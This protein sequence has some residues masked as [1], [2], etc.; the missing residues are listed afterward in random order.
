[1]SVAASTLKQPG[2][3]ILSP[4]DYQGSETH[5]NHKG[6]NRDNRYASQALMQRHSRPQVVPDDDQLRTG[7]SVSGADKDNKATI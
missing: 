1:M 6:M 3:D 4:K 2:L 7:N 5:A